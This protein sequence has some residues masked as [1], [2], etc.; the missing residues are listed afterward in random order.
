VASLLLIVTFISVAILES[1][2]VIVSS[3][4][5]AWAVQYNGV[6]KFGCDNTDD[7]DCTIT[8]NSETDN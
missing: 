5:K 8:I 1:T 2:T 4:G 7:V 6:T 3:K